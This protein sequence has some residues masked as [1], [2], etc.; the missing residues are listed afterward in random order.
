M[1]LIALL[2]VAVVSL[3]LGLALASSV[4]LIVSLV[5]SVLA[6]AAL[7][8]LVRKQRQLEGP[9]PA[10]SRAAK[11]SAG[12]AGAASAAGAGASPARR[13][14]PRRPV[15]P[16]RRRCGP[17]PAR[18]RSRLPI[19]GRSRAPRA[20]A[21]PAP[22]VAAATSADVWV[23]DGFPEYHRAGCS[24]LSG[25]NGE[26][27]PRGQALEDGF[28]PCEVCAPESESESP[29]TAATANSASAAAASSGRQVWV[30]DGYPVS[31]MPDCGELTELRSRRA[32]RAGASRTAPSPAGDQSRRRLRQARPSRGRREGERV[33]I[34]TGPGGE[35]VDRTGRGD[36]W[37]GRGERS[38]PRA[39]T[40]VRPSPAPKATDAG[41]EA[42]AGTCRWP[43]G[44]PSTSANRASS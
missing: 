13:Q 35:A 12:S 1:V 8:L 41:G 27:I 28:T 30:A 33:R 29:G 26:P 11:S 16:P 20:V 36:G 25:R 21:E 5:A 6:A 37:D 3:V 23:V 7:V 31:H 17:A 15:R 19:S 38:R 34:P 9:K 39:A 22:V 24:T 14:V 40:M 43:T 10:K 2:L 32:L 4:W 18:A 44:V 42:R